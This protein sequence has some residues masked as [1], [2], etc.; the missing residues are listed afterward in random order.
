MQRRIQRKPK[1]YLRERSV[2]AQPTVR[3]F[4]IQEAIAILGGITG[5]VVA[6]LWLAGRLYTA[7][8]FGAMNIPAFQ[9]NFS[10]WE[11]AEASWQ[12]LVLIFL[13]KIYLPLV[14]ITSVAFIS[15]LMAFV[16]QR[17]FPKL[18]MVNAL[19]KIASQVTS[20]QRNFHGVLGFAFVL[21]FIYMLL[22][23]FIEI[24]K[25]GAEQGRIAVLKGSY[26][27]EV[28]SKDGVPLG[29]SQV[30]QG[31]TSIFNYYSGFRLLT[32]N[33]GKYYL[34]REIDPSTCKPAEVFVITD[35]QDIYYV[36]GDVAP[37]M[38]TPCDSTST[39]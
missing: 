37:I 22:Q 33:N 11:Y 13:R 10:V 29:P 21:L 20:I 2:T 1:M 3:G 35:T 25:S 23:A 8:Y 18:R 12:R 5:I 36:I 39:P 28:Y 27:I 6:I 7:G 16:L 24:N 31:G 38:N 9:I 15:L 32:H 17:I 30:A 4:N 34:F 14:V 19:K 26:A